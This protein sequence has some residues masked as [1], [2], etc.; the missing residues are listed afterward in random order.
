M[1]RQV[2]FVVT[3]EIGQASAPANVI[4]NFNLLDN[5]PV[6]DLNG[7]G[8]PGNNYATSYSEEAAPVQVGGSLILLSLAS[9]RELHS[10]Y[11]GGLYAHK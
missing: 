2:T 3:D 4:L 1:P 10:L 6:L 9:S 11:F 5:P 7:P 8:V